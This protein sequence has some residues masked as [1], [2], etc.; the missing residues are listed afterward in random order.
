MG[1]KEHISQGDSEY[2]ITG[3]TQI[4]SNMFYI[5]NVEFKLHNI[6]SKWSYFAELEL[7]RP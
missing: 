3:V 1:I 2:C 4:L 7:T 5:T 6:C